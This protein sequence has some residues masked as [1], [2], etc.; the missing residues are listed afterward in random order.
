MTRGQCGWLDLQCIKLS[1]T[2]L[3]RFNRRT[4]IYNDD[5]HQHRLARSEV[6][7]IPAGRRFDSKQCTKHEYF[8][9]LDSPPVVD[10]RRAPVDAHSRGMA[11][12]LSVIQ[13]HDVTRGGFALARI[14]A[15]RSNRVAFIQF[16]E[17]GSRYLA[18]RSLA[19]RPTIA[20]QLRCI[21]A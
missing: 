4:E 11:S 20:N 2:T 19:R 18:K 5:I 21:T 6:E 3:C 17:P 13:P 12:T 16:F 1:F 7:N 8:I 10:G 15:H 14:W 9:R